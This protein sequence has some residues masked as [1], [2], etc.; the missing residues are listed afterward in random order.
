MD[1]SWVQDVAADP[2]RIPTARAESLMPNGS[3]NTDD[4]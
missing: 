3:K 2:Q 4:D 1:V